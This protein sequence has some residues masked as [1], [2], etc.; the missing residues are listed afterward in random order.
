MTIQ[1]GKV[2]VF[3][4]LVLAIGMAG[5]AFGVYTG[6]IDWSNKP[7]RGELAKRQATVKEL[8]TT[9]S[10]AEG[11]QRASLR[12]LQTLEALAPVHQAFYKAEMDHLQ[13]GAN[14]GSPARTVAHQNGQMVFNQNGT[15]QM[16]PAKDKNGQPL[17]SVTHYETELKNTR[18]ATAEAIKLYQKLV[19]Q[20]TKI[21]E[22]IVGDK[23]LR[24]QLFDEEQ[25]KQARV[26]QE[27]EDL[28]PVYVNVLVES[29]LLDKRQKALEKR[30]KELEEK[31]GAKT[32]RR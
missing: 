24:Q 14:A 15:P 16:V 1:W 9:L 23:G 28:K 17:L 10:S 25:V 30:V 26:R 12:T 32:T 20:D 13:S 21:V 4:N 7:P 8:W 6:R 11:R 2:L 19:D 29:Q 22:R 27:I 3:V 5:W 31:L 18:D